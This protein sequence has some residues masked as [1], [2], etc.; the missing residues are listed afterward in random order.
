MQPFYAPER[1]QHKH[2]EY[3]RIISWQDDDNDDAGKL[4]K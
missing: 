4:G 1:T 3:L 2:F